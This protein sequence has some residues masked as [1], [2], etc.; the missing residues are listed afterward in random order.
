MMLCI[1]FY[2]YHGTSFNSAQHAAGCSLLLSVLIAH[3]LEL[4]LPRRFVLHSSNAARAFSAIAIPSQREWHF[5]LRDARFLVARKQL[6]GVN[7]LCVTRR[8]FLRRP[9]TQSLATAVS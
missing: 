1:D 6:L 4:R 8:V 9:S 3:F 5:S 7:V 2:I